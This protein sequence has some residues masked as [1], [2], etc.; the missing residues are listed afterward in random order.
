MCLFTLIRVKHKDPPPWRSPLA[1]A[2][3]FFWRRVSCAGAPHVWHGGAPAPLPGPPRHKQPGVGT[4]QVG[5]GPAGDR[6]HW[7]PWRRVSQRKLVARLFSPPAAAAR[8]PRAARPRPSHGREAVTGR[9]SGEVYNETAGAV[10]QPPHHAFGCPPLPPVDR[11]VDTA[12]YSGG[13]RQ[14]CAL[15]YASAFA[16]H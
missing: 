6:L 9:V 2:V 13:V 10:V 3:V 5:R 16:A 1:Q 7:R 4:L 14:D 15:T 8:G 12:R 11:H